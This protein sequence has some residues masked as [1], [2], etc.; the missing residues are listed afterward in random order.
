MTALLLSN[1]CASQTPTPMD[2]TVVIAMSRLEVK[3][4][5]SSCDQHIGPH[6]KQLKHNATNIAFK[7]AN[8][9]HLKAAH[10][11]LSVYVWVKL[12]WGAKGMPWGQRIKESTL[13]VAA[14]GEGVPP[15][16]MTCCEANCFCNSWCSDGACPP[17]ISNRIQPS[18]CVRAETSMLKEHTSPSCSD[19]YAQ[20]LPG[21]LKLHLLRTIL[22][23]SGYMQISFP[24]SLKPWT[25][26]QPNEKNT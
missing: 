3:T 1:R 26:L 4:I 6:L 13:E 17:T 2:V 9:T 8:T 15:P 14:L 11:S 12:H 19:S 18:K 20:S 16:N 23:F 5:L 25:L 22:V 7:Q 24:S 10:T 21:F